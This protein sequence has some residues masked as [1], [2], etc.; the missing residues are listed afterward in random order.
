MI[1]ESFDMAEDDFRKRQMIEARNEAQTILAA[2]A[3]AP[4][5]AAWGRLTADEKAEIAKRQHDLE[6][7][8][9]GEDYKAIRASI[10]A[11]DKATRNF[12]EM[13]M[14]TAV[15]TAM[16]GRTME[17]ASTEMGDGPTAPHPFAPAEIEER[18]S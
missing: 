10:D 2:V 12:A 4:E 11:L 6:K 7:S 18:R 16:H 5:N 13:M 3:K 15:K 1:L 14:D 17:D 8:A 9:K